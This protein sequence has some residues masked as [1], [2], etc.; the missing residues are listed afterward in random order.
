MQVTVTISDGIIR[1]AA[2]RGMNV[3]EYV[4]SLIDKGLQ[5]QTRPALNSAID[6]IRAIRMGEPAEKF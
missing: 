6:R 2:Y 5:L 3:I 4:E 1:E